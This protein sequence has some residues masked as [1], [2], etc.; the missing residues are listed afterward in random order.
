MA[1]WEKQNSMVFIDASDTPST[2]AWTRV[3]KS[4]VFDL[5]FNPETET[6]DFIDQQFPTDTLKTYKPAM[7]QETM[8]EEGDELFDYMFELM[9]SL[10]TGSSAV[11][12]VLYVFPKKAQSPSGSFVAWKVSCA[13]SFKSYNAVD[14]KL[15]F[16]LA[17]AG[18]IAYGTVA[19]SAG[20]PTFTENASGA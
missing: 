15:S 5:A 10:P 8:L 4:T 17:F 3:R 1:T 14:K 9:Q 7:E 12:P 2:P 16:N 11:R 19:F 6:Q 20:T 13:L 18:D